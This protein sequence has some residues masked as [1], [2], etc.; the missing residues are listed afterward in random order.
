MTVDPN[1]QQK[2]DDIR[3]K[4]YGEQVR[5]SLA[6]GLEAMSSDV[7][8]NVNRQNTVE[9]Q[10][11][12]VI[13]ETTGKDVISAPEIIAARNGEPNLK[14]RLDKE[15]QDLTA[16]LAQNTNYYWLPD[17]QPPARID[18][19]GWFVNGFTGDANYYINTLFE[20]LRSKDPKYVTRESRGKDSSGQYDI[21]K[22]VFEPKNPIKTII[23]TS[24]MHGG[25]VTPMLSMARLL[26]YLVNEPTKNTKLAELRE[27]VRIV[28]VPILNPWGVSQVPRTRYNFNG[29]DINRNFPVGW[30]NY[31][32]SSSAFGHD[33]KGSS[34][35]SERET[36][37]FMEI[38]NEYQGAVAVLD[39]HNTGVSSRDFFY[40]L[41]KNAT[42]NIFPQLTSYLSAE[43]DVEN[44]DILV[45]QNDNP[46]G[47]QWVYETKGIQSSHPEWTD[48]GITGGSMYDSLE[49]TYALTWFA[50][51]ILEHVKQLTPNIT[52]N[53]DTLINDFKN[54]QLVTA[55]NWIRSGLHT[56]SVS[57]GVLTN[58]GATGT[59]TP[60]YG[61][62]LATT[63]LKKGT[64]IYSTIDFKAPLDTLRVG[65]AFR[66]LSAGVEHEIA[67][68]TNPN[69][70]AWLNISGMG[71]LPADTSNLFIRLR[72]YFANNDGG[73]G[74][75]F[76]ITKPL[77]II[78]NRDFD[79]YIPTLSQLNN[80]T[81]FF[82]AEKSVNYIRN[83]S[84]AKREGRNLY[85]SILNL[86]N[87][88]Q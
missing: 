1:I 54:T 7:V 56:T 31:T 21:W 22:Y 84:S 80:L 15:N 87:A 78:I 64:Y 82:P 57:N 75:D 59:S 62:E 74:K 77:T 17:E 58:K 71:K 45:S 50:N 85:Q 35:A 83:L 63:E 43:W 10:F 28:Y 9:D 27:T 61:G 6:S 72:Y 24:V 2:A 81:G 14:S 5:E 25:E 69:P 19:T 36:Q 30:E 60:F 67:S 51:L 11:Q 55:D 53:R 12:Q 8:E 20:P 41:P 46:Y 29:V 48:T 73:A 37:I 40:V 3:T 86:I 42:N 39:L 18:R 76:A 66:D 49:I 47:C 23:I 68:I 44:P 16:Q 26:H 34:P 13:D 79:G 52:F 32:S 38:V 65:L 4:I 70:N 33:W 88:S